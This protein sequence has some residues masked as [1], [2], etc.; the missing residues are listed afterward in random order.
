MK[1]LISILVLM[2]AFYSCESDEEVSPEPEME[3]MLFFEGECSHLITAGFLNDEGKHEYGATMPGDHHLQ[4]YPDNTYT[5]AY[6]YTY[7]LNDVV[8]GVYKR[9]ERGTFTY[10]YEYHPA[11]WEEV[12][13]GFNRF[14]SAAYWNGS[15]TFSPEGGQPHTARYSVG[16]F[17]KSIFLPVDS[18]LLVLCIID[19]YDFKQ[20]P[21][22]E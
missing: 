15:V 2:F 4:F 3:W 18:G 9:D 17:Y 14:I 12:A 6:D 19:C 22:G 5:L 1:I 20:I 21:S 11:V 16:T 13:P 7:M 10:S 8:K